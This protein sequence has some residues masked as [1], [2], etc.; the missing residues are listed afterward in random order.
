VAGLLLATPAI[1]AEPGLPPAPPL[2]EVEATWRALVEALTLGDREGVRQLTHSS[3]RHLLP[4]PL[5]VAPAEAYQLS[6]CR[7]QPQPLRLQVDELVY[8]VECT[9]FGE[10][11]EMVL[12][13][14][15]DRDRVWR[16]LAF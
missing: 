4:D 2:A 1:S 14:R 6:F 3:R 8:R 10:Q 15:R 13:L 7:P 16:I 11:A 9:A 5:P 12:H